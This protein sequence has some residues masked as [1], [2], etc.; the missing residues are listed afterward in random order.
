[1]KSPW[2][3]STPL[4]P[5]REYLVL[6]SSIPPRSR[7]STWRLYRGASAVR[8][9]LRVTDGVIGFALLARPFRKEYATLSVWT[10]E[11]ALANFASD[12]P[13][14]ELMRTLSPKMGPTKFVRWTMRGAEGKPSWHDA[15]RRLRTDPANNLTQ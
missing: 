14:R 8:K 6:A 4:D 1:M 5:E 12:D 3:W 15:M 7:R 10:G 9:Q 2:K 13:H 11:D